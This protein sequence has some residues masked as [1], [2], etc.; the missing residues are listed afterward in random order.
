MET[1]PDQNELKSV[2]YEPLEPIR[3]EIRLFTVQYDP[4]IDGIACRLIRC[5]LDDERKPPYM[6]LSYVWGSTDDYHSVHVNDSIFVV[7]KNLFAALSALGR[8]LVNGEHLWVDTI[9]INQ[10]DVEER[11]R[12]VALMGRIYA[13]ADGIY[14]WLGTSTWELSL[15]MCFANQLAVDLRLHSVAPLNFSSSQNALIRP[16]YSWIWG[17]EYEGLL[18]ESPSPGSLMQAFRYLF[19]GAPYWTRAWTYQELCLARGGYMFCGRDRIAIQDVRQVAYWF[20]NTFY[21]H[22]IARP[23]SATDQMWEFMNLLRQYSGAMLGVWLTT[24]YQDVSGMALPEE[25]KAGAIL[26]RLTLRRRATDARDK[27][28]SILGLVNLDWKADYGQSVERVYT[29]FAARLLRDPPMLSTILR[30]GGRHI[31]SPETCTNIPS[32]VPDYHAVSYAEHRPIPDETWSAASN[33]LPSGGGQAFYVDGSILHCRG[34][35]VE[36]ITQVS[37]PNPGDFTVAWE[38]S[39]AASQVDALSTLFGCAIADIWG[40][41][42]RQTRYPTGISLL[43]AVLRTML[44]DKVDMQWIGQLGMSSEVFQEHARHFLKVIT[45]IPDEVSLPTATMA[46]VLE[47]SGR[48]DLQLED[49]YG[50][51]SGEADRGYES[52]VWF[53]LNEIASVARFRTAAGYIGR[54]G[55]HPD[56]RYHAQ[57]GHLI[58]VLEGCN[59]PVILAKVDEHYELVSECFILGYMSGEAALLVASGERKMQEFAIH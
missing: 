12:Q 11:N 16:G 33:G 18:A 3:A 14:S 47:L 52:R 27:I 58:C 29:D 32:W 53:M 6:A 26:K 28:F 35:V 42:L 21:A 43:A 41:V 46:D 59:I 49:V 23:P 20:H 36:E 8:T 19:S 40:L 55:L 13:E 2:V 31:Q 17:P 34:I 1:A 9:C 37:V 57:P 54:A 56:R 45:T 39:K 24:T 25:R 48:A 30:M 4:S 10:R 22:E 50:L 38:P 15:A 7:T 5:S 44:F 51:I